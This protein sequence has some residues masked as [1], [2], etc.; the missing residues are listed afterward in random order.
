MRKFKALYTNEM[1]KISRKYVVIIITGIMILGLFAY[2]GI[3]KISE[4][5]SSRYDQPGMAD[6]ENDWRKEE[7]K[8]MLD[9]FKS[10]K[11]KLQQELDSAEDEAG[12][13]QIEYQ[14]KNLDIQIEVYEYA[15]A[16]NVYFYA[17]GYIAESLRSLMD[18]KINLSQYDM[19]PAEELNDIQ[20]KE[21]ASLNKRIEKYEQIIEETDYGTYLDFK[22]ELI[23]EDDSLTADE[24]TI[25]KESVELRRK[26]DPTGAISVS[27]VNYDPIESFLQTIESIKRSL[28]SNID[29]TSYGTA[30]PLAPDDRK[31][32]ENKLAVE[33]YKLEN[34][35]FSKTGSNGFMSTDFTD[36]AMKGMLNFG[37]FM[38]VCMV[39][40]LAGGAVSQEISSGSIKS[41]IIAPVKRYKIFFAK[42]ASIVTAGLAMAVILYVVSVFVHGIMFG[43]SS[44]TDY[45][46]AVN[47]K[48]RELDFYIY[49]LANIGID[50]ID[51][52]VYLVFAYML[53]I[54]TRNTAVS[55]GVSIAIYFGGNL[56]NLFMA[57]TEIFSG[58]WTKFVPF[59]NM[60]LSSRIFSDSAGSFDISAVLGINFN[61]PSVLFSLCYLAVMLIC[62]GYTALDSF[63]RRDI[64]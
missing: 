3:I 56:V 15:V 48:A 55:V 45:I 24:K 38:M 7:M 30:K 25:K 39:L 13:Q 54:I 31:T 53:S 12:R 35:D 4:I 42:L 11:L 47:G 64:K 44:G 58:E 46:Y 61:A 10:E 21:I 57:A 41:L 5:T 19:I 26:I 17:G 50:F 16:K 8:A 62:F 33:I 63:N 20:K 37:R 2:S 59:N 14:I 49:R 22:E 36:V 51:V 28:L 52:L 32:L 6:Q 60:A 9:N 23:D 27:A 18:A 29:Y 40:I 1:I 43:F 34:K